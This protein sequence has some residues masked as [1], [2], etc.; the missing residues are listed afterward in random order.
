MDLRC[1]CRGRPVRVRYPDAES[2]NAK[3]EKKCDCNDGLKFFHVFLLLSYRRT[4]VAANNT[5]RLAVPTLSI[6]IS[7]SAQ[8]NAHGRP[9]S[10]EMPA[11]GGISVPPDRAGHD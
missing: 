5:L 11:G 8:R 1:T 3:R 10:D 9:Y 4:L 6:R 7:P 2:Q